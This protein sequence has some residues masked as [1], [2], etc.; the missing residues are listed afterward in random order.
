M[1]RI[2]SL[3]AGD[4]FLL[5]AA[6]GG[7]GLIVCQWAKLLGFNVIGTVSTEAKAEIA[8]AHGCDHIIFY[9]REDVAQRVREITGGEGVPVVFDSVGKDTMMG[10]INSLRR[11]GL[12][13]N[14]PRSD[15]LRFMPALTVTHDEI[16]QMITI[17]D[18]MLKHVRDERRP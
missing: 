12:L 3:K 6:A 5:H 4:T 18:A 7:V 16:D 1:R 15:S 10:S 11:R 2:S 9:G 14:A 13:V 17:L 8:R